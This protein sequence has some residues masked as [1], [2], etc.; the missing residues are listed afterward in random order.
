[1]SAPLRVGMIGVG[2]V[3]RAYFE[4]LER[5]PNLKL[6]AVAD[7]DE[8]RA[9][10]VAA[11]RG[12]DARSVDGLLASDDV[13]AVVNL[14]IPAAHVE[15]GL[16]ALAAGK[17]VYSEKPLGLTT[18]EARPLIE[19]QADGLRVGSAP[20]TV[21]GTGIQTA[22]RVIDDGAIGEPL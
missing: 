8:A 20:D 9:A 1:M 18:A 16:R 4:S 5:L 6:V 13:E 7:I 21:L 14:T 22:R 12:V 2:V 3:S 10:Q 19:A 17:H 15:V 11:E